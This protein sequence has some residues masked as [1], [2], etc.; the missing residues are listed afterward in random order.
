MHVQ[1]ILVM[2]VFMFHFSFSSFAPCFILG[3]CL[4]VAACSEQQAYTPITKTVM[5]VNPSAANE[6]EKRTLSGVLRP[7]D[8][9]VL[10]FEIPGVVQTVNVNLGDRFKKGDVLASIDSKLFELA[11]RQRQGQLSEAKSRL[12]EAKVDYERKSKLSESG[13]ISQADVDVAKARYQSLLDQVEIAETQVAIALEDLAD[14]QLI[15]PYEGSIAI[16]HV[17]PSQQISPSSAIFTI[18]GSDALEVSVLVPESMI[19]QIKTGDEVQV[20]VIINRQRQS[21]AGYVFERGNQAQE[22]NAFP[23]TVALKEADS[24][25]A[26]RTG[27]LQ[28]GMSAEATFTSMAGN[29]PNGSLRA[30]LSSVAADN[31][32]EHFVMALNPSSTPSPLGSQY[33]IQKVAVTV[34]EFHSEYVIF[35]PQSPIQKLVKSGVDFVRDGQVVS[36]AGEYPRTINQ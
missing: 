7:V 25:D 13:A 16:R 21:V 23:V 30:P 14:T 6:L 12:T 27:A 28:S 34:H 19:A 33:E 9:S 35:T 2:S 10:S 29:V 26:K 32:N 17:E 31:N 1:F 3:A 4:L 8:E 36:V 15:A 22:A 20:D 5:A 18:Q 24:I 11:V